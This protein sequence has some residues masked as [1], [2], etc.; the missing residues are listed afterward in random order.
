[1]GKQKTVNPTVG[2]ITM[3]IGRSLT[4]RLANSER[5]VRLYFELFLNSHDE[6]DAVGNNR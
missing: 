4:N 5:K 3:I 6:N 2:V 1:M